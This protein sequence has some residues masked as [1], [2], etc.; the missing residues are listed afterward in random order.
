MAPPPRRGGACGVSDRGVNARSGLCVRRSL[1]RFR[2]LRQ[3]SHAT[4]RARTR[5]SGGR[6]RGSESERCVVGGIAVGSCSD[7]EILGASHWERAPSFQRR[8]ANIGA[9]SPRAAARCAARCAIRRAARQV[10]PHAE[11]LRPRRAA[12]RRWLLLPDGECDNCARAQ[13][14]AH[15]PWPSHGLDGARLRGGPRLALV[16]V[17]CTPSV[18]PTVDLLS[19]SSCSIHAPT[20]DSEPY[21]SDRSRAQQRA[22][23]SSG[24]RSSL[25]VAGG[26]HE[27]AGGRERCSHHRLHLSRRRGRE[28]DVA[29]ATR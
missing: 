22:R 13:H 8:S 29:R 19:H 2:A 26:E 20:G 12:R 16:T 4:R 11:L 27:R 7:V 17:S 21:S 14:L 24:G 5:P 28:H 1:Q 6:P 18:R 3:R 15:R 9:P 25:A 23:A 10:L